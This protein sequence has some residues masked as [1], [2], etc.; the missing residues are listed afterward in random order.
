LTYKN[1]KR[2]FG[3]KSFFQAS[4]KRLSI[5]LDIENLLAVIKTANLANAVVLYKCVTSRVGTLVHAG[6]GEL[7][8]VGTS[9]VSAC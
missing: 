5:L 8:V 4:V 7:A 9:L 3:R 6:Q 1:E 2:T